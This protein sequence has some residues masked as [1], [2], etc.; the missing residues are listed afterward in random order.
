MPHCDLHRKMISG[1]SQSWCSLQCEYIPA[2]MG[3]RLFDFDNNEDS[4]INVT[5]DA[6]HMKRYS[7]PSSER[8]ASS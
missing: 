6:Q 1:C 7:L 2:E 4:N 8:A 3:G 5:F